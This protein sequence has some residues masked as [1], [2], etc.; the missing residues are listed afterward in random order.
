MIDKLKT[1]GLEKKVIETTG[2][3]PDAYFSASKIAWILEN[4]DG[5]RKLADED[6]LLFGTIDTWLIYNLTGGKV[7]VTDYTNASRTM[8][9]DIKNLCWDKEL[10]EYFKIP[11]PL[12]YCST[13][14]NTTF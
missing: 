13:S 6:K 5:A 9:Y 12:H 2:L 1:D 7:H 8:L 10:L 3:I 11:Q 14:K 4:V